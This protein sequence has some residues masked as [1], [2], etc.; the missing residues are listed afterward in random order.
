MW[1]RIFH[2]YT[3]YIGIYPILLAAISAV[4]CIANY[5]PGTFLTGWDTLHPEF[6]FN[7]AFSR[8]LNGVWRY[9]QGLGAVAI[10]SHM[11]D[12]PRV[13]L[14]WL[15][16]F[17]V[18]LSLLRYLT[19]FIALIMGPIGV[20]LFVTRVGNRRI[21]P[22]AAFFAGLSYLA[23]LTTAQHFAVPLEMFAIQ[24]AFLPWLFLC[25]HK[26]LT[27][28]SKNAYVLF[29]L[30]NILAA[31]Q[32]QTAT[33]FYAYGASLC[34][35]LIVFVQTHKKT[36]HHA[37]RR[38]IY[39]LGITIT[40]NAFWLLP[41]I[42][43]VITQANAVRT[44]AVNLLFSEEAFRKNQLYGT[45]NNAFI[46]KNFL[47]SWQLVN[48]ITSQPTDVLA[49]WNNALRSPI[50]Q[51]YLWLLPVLTIFGIIRT[52]KQKLW[53]YAPYI[54]LYV[55]PLILIAN[56]EW[57]VKSM[58]EQLRIMLPVVGEA[59]RFPFTKFSLLLIFATTPFIALAV[60][61]LITRITTKIAAAICILTFTILPIIAF[62]PAF[63]GN[64]I[65]PAM[66]IA[67]PSSYFDLFR[68]LSSQ[69]S[70][71]KI[72]IL[73]ASSFWNWV[74][75][76]WGYQGAGFLQFGIP[77]PIL[78]RDYDRWN[79]INEAYYWELSRAIYTKDASQV[80]SVFTKYDISMVL[81]DTSVV[82]RDHNR[83][84]YLEEL[85]TMLAAMPEFHIEKTFGSVS[86]YRRNDRPP[87]VSIATDLPTVFSET[88]A[89]DN[90]QAYIQLGNYITTNQK[91]NKAIIYPFRT[92][93]SK[94]SEQPHFTVT[95][96]QETLTITAEEATTLLKD[97]DTVVSVS[98][99]DSLFIS[100][101]GSAPQPYNTS[102]MQ[103]SNTVI[104][105]TNS[106]RN[107]CATYGAPSLSTSQGYLVAIEHR[108]IAGMSAILSI[109][110]TTAKHEE[111]H[112]ALPN[113]TTLATSYVILP[114]LASDGKGYSVTVVN[115]AFG[116]IQSIND[117]GT[118]TFYKVPYQYLL[119]QR[120]DLPPKQPSQTNTLI[121]STAYHPGWIAI[122]TT[123]WKLLPHVL[124]NNWKNGWTTPSTDI[125]HI[126]I[127]FWPQV[128]E[129]IGFLLIPVSL[130]FFL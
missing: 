84:L 58:I 96:T 51:A 60:D 1:K 9:D 3:K 52:V 13:I 57:P 123:T 69:P 18:P 6:N 7:L 129:Y 16:S 85:T 32:A 111:V 90:D 120:S 53:S 95:N 104:R 55:L 115:Q 71:E 118:I 28:P 27:R 29:F 39:I 87:A 10:Q 92:L 36:N 126:I 19:F 37:L 112:I 88:Y 125:S 116:D 35:F 40:S 14:L 81:I 68:W 22:F 42:Y 48:P 50:V 110:N 62:I 121:A 82:S 56:N 46:Q 26:I 113:T 15:T 91:N 59:L 72:A 99:P 63:Q 114:P 100:P 8:M 93:F 119:S 65:H 102:N 94:R 106:K 31:P 83:A 98:T 17:L 122:D 23:N 117:I 67:I 25:I 73:P 109:Q 80:V 4:I 77:Q 75:Y 89:I 70:D 86:I 20:S 43:A 33:L 47:F 128:L 74:N 34:I 54:P 61:W 127:I 64:L 21:H 79:P 2:I 24:Y 108:H 45:W 124:I 38:A 12:L 130:I 49:S 107:V 76:R 101:C 5:T 105:L 41:N 78:D 66:R 103:I 30:L 11:A 97:S 44:S